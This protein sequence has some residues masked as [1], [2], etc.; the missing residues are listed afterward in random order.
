MILRGHLKGS[1]QCVAS[2]RDPTVTRM[3][4]QPNKRIRYYDNFLRVISVEEGSATLKSS[5]IFRA[6]DYQPGDTLIIK[7]MVVMKM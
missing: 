5:A 3:A 6:A 4:K 1:R 2:Y 7:I